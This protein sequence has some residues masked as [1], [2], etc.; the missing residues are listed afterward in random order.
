MSTKK[1][2]HN[3]QLGG[4]RPGVVVNRVGQVVR[5]VLYRALSG[6]DGLYKESEHGEHSQPS[7]LD[8]L[9]LQLCKRIWVFRQAQ[10]VKATPR[11]QWVDH[12]TKRPAGNSVALNGSHEDDLASPDGQDA[13]GV[14]QARVPQVVEP[15]LAEDLGPGL[16]PHCLAE[17][18]SVA[19]QKLREDAAQSAQ[20][21]PSAVD[22]LKLPVLGEGLWIGGK[23]GGVP[24]VVSGEL[25]GE[26]AGGLAGERAEVLDAVGTVPRAAGGCGLG[27]GG[28]LPHGD[29][30]LT[31]K[32]GGG[33]R[34]L[35]GLAG[36][37]WGGEG[38]C[39]GCH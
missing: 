10:R 12:L 9:H 32:L 18:D 25:A 24:A 19:G 8:L 39:G 11:V 36:E 16:E 21:G 38:H 35:N 6:D 30:T 37:G 3:H 22:H 5:Q 34:E 13:L 23:S 29:A 15:A 17:L 28:G 1:V 26:V 7:V 31:E 2:Q 33:G 4:V 14:D 20:H 27:L